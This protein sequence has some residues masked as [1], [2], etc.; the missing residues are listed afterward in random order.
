MTKL[1]CVRSADIGGWNHNIRHRVSVTRAV[2]VCDV[3]KP[4]RSQ[5]SAC[6]VHGSVSKVYGNT[7]RDR[8]VFQDEYTSTTIGGL[9]MTTST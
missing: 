5:K 6:H 7:R 4:L 3:E 2:Q 1:R 8:D 9:L